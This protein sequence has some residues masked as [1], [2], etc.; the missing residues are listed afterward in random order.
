MWVNVLFFLGSLVVAAYWYLTRN[1][2]WFRA[3]GIYEHDNAFPMWCPEA[4]QIMMG[5][6]A[7]QR[8]LEP[9]YFK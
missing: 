6:V 5:R 7:M 4:N 8:M 9:I 1:F 2:G 3:R